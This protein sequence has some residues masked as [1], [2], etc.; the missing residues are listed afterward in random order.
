MLN[1]LSFSIFAN[2]S[3]RLVYIQYPVYLIIKRKIVSLL[4]MKCPKSTFK[5]VVKRIEMF[6]RIKQL[7]RF[8]IFCDSK[9]L[10]LNIYLIVCI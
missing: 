5:N 10:S 2:D 9:L 7:A 3:K 6:L 4:M 8:F 1:V